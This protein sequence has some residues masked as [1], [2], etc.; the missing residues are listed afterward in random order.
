M[1][2]KK[3]INVK[4]LIKIKQHIYKTRIVNQ[5]KFLFRINFISDKTGTIDY[6]YKGHWTLYRCLFKRLISLDFGN[7]ISDN[8]FEIEIENSCYKEVIYTGKNRM[9]YVI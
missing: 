5:E 4:T 8:V 1:S 9:Y 7:T 2:F 6:F 3:D